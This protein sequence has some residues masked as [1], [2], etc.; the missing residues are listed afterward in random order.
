MT[1][2][3]TTS[4]KSF[5][6]LATGDFISLLGTAVFDLALA[7]WVVSKTGS[8]VLTGYILAATLAP[9]A[10]IGP[11]GG[12]LC[13]RWN[14]KK[15]IIIT[16]VISG[17]V[18]VGIAVLVHHGVVNVPLLLTGCFVLG[19]CASLH[20]PAVRSMVPTL[21][22]DHYL[23]RAN[24]ISTNLSETTKAV[25]PMLGAALVAIPSVG[26]AG[27]LTINGLSFWA[28][29]A[30]ETFI[31]YRHN[32]TGKN[33]AGVGKDL[34]DGFVYI[35]RHILIR[36][37]V[38]LCGVVNFFLVAFNILLPVYVTRVLHG[39]SSTY[40]HALTAE[41][42]GGIAV[43]L[44]MLLYRD[45]T[46]SNRRLA[47][48]ITAGG[49]AL[50]LMPLV[51]NQP[52]LLVLSAAQGLFVGAFNTLFF[53]HIQKT[54]SQEYLGRIFSVVY[55]VAIGVMPL[56]YIAWGYVGDFAIRWSLAYA[57]I[58]TILCSVP[59]GLSRVTAEEPDQRRDEMA[60]GMT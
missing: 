36:N 13:D 42:V 7:W 34:R 39:T 40:G 51:P 37:M 9:I 45:V 10:F 57:G 25:G 29:A 20:R 33:I 18:A 12:V 31:A 22:S 21:V 2:A 28:A 53:T 49:S 15:I 47:A 60:A 50:A 11:V 52:G 23:V 17:G 41:A 35:G 55:M 43:S 38:V 5:G 56:S 46:V 26:T 30:S 3:S 27:A 24:S 4:R 59:F 6:A 19:T 58:G 8:A 16:D 48:L 1:A 14:K 44:A 54:V 32:A